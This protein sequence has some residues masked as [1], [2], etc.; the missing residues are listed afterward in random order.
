VNRVDLQEKGT[1]QSW[2]KRLQR[3]SAPGMASEW[4]ESLEIY[5]LFNGRAGPFKVPTSSSA[6][7]HRQLRRG[8]LVVSVWLDIEF[9]WTERQTRM[10]N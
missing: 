10:S 3:G 6:Q 8:Y 2:Y 4:D 7:E 1:G 9:F 5:G